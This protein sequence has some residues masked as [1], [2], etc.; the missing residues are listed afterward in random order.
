MLKGYQKNDQ[1]S[2]WFEFLCIAIHVN[3][4][5]YAS[6]TVALGLQLNCWHTYPVALRLDCFGLCAALVV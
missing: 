4:C 5:A 1:L 6:Q 3:I 2:Q